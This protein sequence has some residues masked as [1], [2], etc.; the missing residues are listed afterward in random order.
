MSYDKLMTH[1]DE[2]GY[3][4]EKLSSKHYLFM[5]T[6]AENLDVYIRWWNEL[7]N[8]RFYSCRF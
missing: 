5:F 2:S 1:A 4:L 8:N 7:L 3:K 6:N